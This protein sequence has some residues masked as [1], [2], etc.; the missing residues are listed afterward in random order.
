MFLLQHQGE[1]V[2]ADPNG[3]LLVTAQDETGH[4]YVALTYNGSFLVTGDPRNGRHRALRG[5]MPVV[6]RR[7]HHLLRVASLEDGIRTF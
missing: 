1:L 2:H 3:F 6:E 4:F 7:V 5:F